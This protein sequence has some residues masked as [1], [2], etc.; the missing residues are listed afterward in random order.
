MTVTM[1][2]EKERKRDLMEKHQRQEMRYRKKPK[3]KIL[4]RR[5]KLRL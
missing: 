3:R 1:A 2:Q 4:L 5:K